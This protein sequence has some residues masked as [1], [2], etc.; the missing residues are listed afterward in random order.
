VTPSTPPD[1]DTAAVED[2]YRQLLKMLG[3]DP[4]SDGLR[5][6]P[7]RVAAFWRDFLRPD[8]AVTGTTFAYRQCA[9]D[10]V[11]VSGIEAWTLCQH[12]LLPFHVTVSAAYVPD[13]KIIGLSKIARIV[14]GHAAGLQV[15]ETLTQQV[16]VSLAGVTASPAVGV[17]AAGEHLCM[18]MR[19]ARAARART[20]TQTLLGSAAS[21]PHLERRLHAAAHP[22]AG[23][24]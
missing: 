17:W 20:V 24:L 16:A 13:G 5:D 4:D 21:D 12:H 9:G 22:P 1:I 6:T 18:M 7:G 2:L 11:A 8:P 3:Q 14:A 10:L 19:G 23:G 15:Q